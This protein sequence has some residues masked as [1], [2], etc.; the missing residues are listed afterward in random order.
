MA[1]NL[2]D[3]PFDQFQEMVKTCPTV[4][5]PVGL[6]EQHGHHLPLGTDVFNSTE[7]L[8]IGFDRINAFIAPGLHYCFSGGGIQGYNEP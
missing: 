6:I 8:R 4:I 1:Y 5:L 7:P 2:T 3:Y